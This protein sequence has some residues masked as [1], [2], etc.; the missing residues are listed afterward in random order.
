MNLLHFYAHYYYLSYRKTSNNS[1]LY[2][3]VIFIDKILPVSI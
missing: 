3:M 1:L 2:Q